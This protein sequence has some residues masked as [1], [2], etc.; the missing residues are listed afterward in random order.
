MCHVNK[1]GA[2]H[3]MLHAG[4][5]HLNEESNPI[6]LAIARHAGILHSDESCSQ[7]KSPLGGGAQLQVGGAQPW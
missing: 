4:H 6:H 2:Q 7:H 5:I 3:H 1:V